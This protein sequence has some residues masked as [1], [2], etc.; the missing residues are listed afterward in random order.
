MARI[1]LT[2]M[3]DKLFSL[4]ITQ[5]PFQLRQ[6]SVIDKLKF[7]GHQAPLAASLDG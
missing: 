6:G 5:F 3:S 1:G 7:V 2:M 4:S